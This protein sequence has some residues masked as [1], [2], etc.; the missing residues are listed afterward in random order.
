V[1]PVVWVYPAD[2][3]GCGSYR[4]LFPAAALAAE[5]HPVEVVMPGVNE[6][7]QCLVQTLPS[8]RQVVKEVTAPAC[9]VVVLQRPLDDVMVQLVPELQ[10]RDIAVVVEVDDDFDQ[11]HPANTSWRPVQPR[12][13][14][15]SNREHLHRACALADLVTVTTPSLAAR[16]GG[17]G[18]VRIIPNYV[19]RWYLGLEREPHDGVVC[20]W[21]GSIETHPTDLEVVGHGLGRAVAQAGARFRVIGPGEEVRQRLGLW[22]A[23]ETSGFVPIDRYPVELAGLDVGL[24]PLALIPFNE[25]KSSLKPLEYAATGVACVASPTASYRQ[26]AR[27]GLCELAETRRDWERAVRRLAGDD[28]HR[29]QVAGRARQAAAAH[30]IE[31]HLEQWEEAWTA[32]MSHAS[33]RLSP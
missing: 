28:E 3:S 22:S 27:S 2:A 6:G 4:C 10:A 19:P 24:A 1:T 16:Y 13:S 33:T 25:A 29:A 15:W 8:G 18:R 26:A 17:H 5:G 32:S 23:P 9:D 7:I 21:A 20:G 31:D 12:H 30:V 11:V 14:P